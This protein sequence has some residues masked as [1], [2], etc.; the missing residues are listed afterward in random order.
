LTDEEL[1][2]LE[3]SDVLITDPM[4]IEKAYQAL[5]QRLPQ[6]SMF[7]YPDFKKCM[8]IVA[9]RDVV[10]DILGVKSRMLVPFADMLNRKNEEVTIKFDI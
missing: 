5:C 7:S 1:P 2:F 9:S 8:Y 4:H 3:A 10:V 6:M